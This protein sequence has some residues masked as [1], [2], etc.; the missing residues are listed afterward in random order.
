MNKLKGL[1]DLLVVAVD[2]GATAVE[3]V[4]REYAGRT[5]DAVGPAAAP[6]RQLHDLCLTV[7]YGQVRAVTRAVGM[8]LDL[9]LKSPPGEGAA[10]SR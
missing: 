10:R 1:K 7:S 3:G 2:Q 6:V 9:V 8:A 5:F 4:H